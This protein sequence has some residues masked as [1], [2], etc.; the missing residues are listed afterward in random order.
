MQPTILPLS[1]L[2]FGA[3][4]VILRFF[5][6]KTLTNDNTLINY[7]FHNKTQLITNLYKYK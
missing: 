6:N 2:K 3:N 1:D 7:L 4:S 5:A